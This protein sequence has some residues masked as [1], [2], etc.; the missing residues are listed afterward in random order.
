MARV[1]RPTY[2]KFVGGQ[3][4]TK[5]YAKWYAKVMVN[6][7]RKAVP[8]TTDKRASEIM[9]ADLLKREAMVRACGSQQR[10]AG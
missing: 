1:Y 2:R 9:L 8:L 4:V 6:G 10:K 7:V 5:R 3:W